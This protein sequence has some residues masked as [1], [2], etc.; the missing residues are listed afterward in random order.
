MSCAQLFAQ[1]PQS[2]AQLEQVSFGSQLPSPQTAPPEL[3]ELE[4][5]E[6]EDDELEDDD[7][8][9][10]LL[11]EDDDA[12][13]DAEDDDAPLELDEEALLDDDDVV[14]APPLAPLPEAEVD[15]PLGDE[16]DE[17]LDDA[18]TGSPMPDEAADDEAGPAPAPLLP[19]APLPPKPPP[20]P[21]PIASVP[22]DPF[23]QLKAAD[24]STANTRTGNARERIDFDSVR[25]DSATTA[26][27]AANDARFTAERRCV[28]ELMGR[29][30]ANTASPTCETSATR[31]GRSL[32]APTTEPRRSSRTRASLGRAV[33]R[34]L[35][36]R[37]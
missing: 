21:A 35:V 37:A 14:D 20:P 26:R 10:A 2:C 34:G 11:D 18:A 23:A 19:P 24:A 33:G 8:D 28:N 5:D 27:C 32:D 17:P 36:P 15:E 7:D 25:D 6:L 30:Q 4:D 1:G 12:L 16:E 9:D 22:S 3:D 13:L 31:T 29:A